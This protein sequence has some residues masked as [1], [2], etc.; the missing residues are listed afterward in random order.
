M[1]ELK[2]FLGYAPGVGKTYSMLNEGNRRLRRG[3]NVVI[4]YLEHHNRKDTIEQIGHLKSIPLKTIEHKGKLFDELN[5]DVIISEKPELVL[6]DELAHSNIQGSKNPK[7]YM[8]IL[9]LLE[10]D[11]N[12]YTTLNLQHLESL[13]DIIYKITGTKI[14]ETVPDSILDNATVVVVDIT[15]DALRN[16]VKRGDIYKGNLI[17]SSLHNFFRKGNLT[18]LRE[19]TLRQLADEVDEELSK[20]KFEHNLNENWQTVERIMVSI[21]SSPSSKRLIRMGARIAKKYKCEFYCVYI[22][23]THS[24]APKLSE[25][26]LASLDENIKLAS[27]LHAQVIH[28]KGPYVSKEIINFVNSKSITKLLLGHSRRTF[29]QKLFRGSLVNRVLEGVKDIEVI[30]IPYN[31]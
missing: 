29:F 18:A 10:N 16:R 12:V 11:I 13:N 23:S 14:N 19:L 30:I 8:D 5:L 1:A 2:V 15:P 27:K 3:E 20:Y 22:E 25:K 24:F 26:D 9:E 6:V 17:Y 31:K 7:R 21:S 4:G 28:L